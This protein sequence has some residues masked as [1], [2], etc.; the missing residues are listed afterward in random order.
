MACPRF[1]NQG[2]FKSEYTVNLDFPLPGFKNSF[3]KGCSMY[4][5]GDIEPVCKDLILLGGMCR[6][7]FL[8][9]PIFCEE[10]TLYRVYLEHCSGSDCNIGYI[11]D[12]L[13]EETTTEISLPPTTQTSPQ[14]TTRTTWSTSTTT[15]SRMTSTTMMSTAPMTEASPTPTT[16]TTKA[17]TTKTMAPTPSSTASITTPT[18]PTN[19]TPVPDEPVG[20]NAYFIFYC[21]E[22]LFLTILLL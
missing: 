19:P 2:C 10:S 8:V 12:R 18:L 15:S 3:N 11:G 16:A 21:I 14:P 13:P 20:D 17:S 4:E 7:K 5:L 1:A 6:G 22:L 9:H